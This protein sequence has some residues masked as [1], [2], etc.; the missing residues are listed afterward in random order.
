MLYHQP[1]RW[2]GDHVQ[3]FPKS[4]AGDAADIVANR[5]AFQRD[6]SK[7]RRDCPY[8]SPNASIRA[9]KRRR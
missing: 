8:A 3:V 1:E 2:G 5:I 4:L 6:H 7:R 9:R